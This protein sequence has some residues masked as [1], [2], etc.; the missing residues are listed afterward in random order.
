MRTRLLMSTLLCVVAAPAL[1][2][3][4]HGPGPGHGPEVRHDEHPAVVRHEERREERH[5]VRVDVRHDDRVEHRDV[6]RADVHWG[7]V[8]PPPMRFERHDAFRPGYAWVGG[9][10][11]WDGAHYGWVGGNWVAAR[12]GFRWREPRWELRD[13]VYVQIDGGWDPLAAGVTIVGPRLAPPEIRVEHWDDRPG[14]VWIRGHYDWNDNAYVW[15]GGHYDHDRPGY[16]WHEPHWEL[17][18]DAYVQVD[19]GWER[20][21]P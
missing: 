19:G 3:P 15:V 1:A 4:H 13:G 18:G 14:F 6:I 10:W 8:G 7:R 21:I 16:R 20:V 5:D 17:Q 11:N 2:D 9:R 12:P